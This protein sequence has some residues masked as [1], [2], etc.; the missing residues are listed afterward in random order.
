[1]VTAPEPSE[2]KIATIDSAHSGFKKECERNSHL[3]FK[4]PDVGEP[5]L[6]A[7][8]HMTKSCLSD[9]RAAGCGYIQ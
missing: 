6:P 1:M 8:Y 2:R 5:C 4:N 9:R 7:P 3:Q